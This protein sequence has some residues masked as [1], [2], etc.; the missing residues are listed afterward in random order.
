[1]TPQ[2]QAALA[3]VCQQLGVD[4]DAIAFRVDEHGVAGAFVGPAYAECSPAG[5]VEL[6]CDCEPHIPYGTCAMCPTC[7]RH[8]QACEAN[9]CDACEQCEALC[10]A[11]ECAGMAW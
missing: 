10:T 9:R 4:Y 1:M 8:L 7:T 5:E 11:S 6:W 2:Q 3:A